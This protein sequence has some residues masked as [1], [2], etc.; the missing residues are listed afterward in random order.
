MARQVQSE[1]LILFSNWGPRIPLFR[2]FWLGFERAVVRFPLKL[3]SY[4][5]IVIIVHLRALVL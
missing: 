2:W 3:G 4:I 1:L 5:V